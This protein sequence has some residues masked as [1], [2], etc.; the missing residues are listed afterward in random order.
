MDDVFELL[1]QLEN[2]KNDNIYYVYY[3][4]ITGNIMHIRNYQETDEFPCLKV[5]SDLLSDE[6]RSL[7][8]YKVVEKQ[9]EYSLIKLDK[10]VPEFKI[11]DEIYQIEKYY[12]RNDVLG[13][14]ILIEQNNKSKEFKIKL[15]D[16]LRIRLEYADNLSNKMILY[17]T[18]E[19]DP[20]ILY[21]TIDISIR[22]LIDNIFKIIDFDD[23]DGTPCNIF[24]R[25]I[26]ENYKHL[27]KRQ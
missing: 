13:Y 5:E 12:V 24:T 22:Y 2:N 17:V 26:F 20:N 18:A 23:Y 4:P 21:K 1:K 10:K 14:D 16:E 15:S 19:N 6:N 11:N 27:D 9:G 8:D 7:T 3:D 25:K